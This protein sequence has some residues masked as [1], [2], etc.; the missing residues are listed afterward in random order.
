M[1]RVICLDERLLKRVLRVLRVAH[2]RERQ[3]E[4]GGLVRPYQR[5]VESGVTALDLP[6]QFALQ[7]RLQSRLPLRDRL[8]ARAAR[9]LHCWAMTSSRAATKTSSSSSVLK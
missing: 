9:N 7:V 6:H 3:T 2:H 1:Q 4:S 5:L 8:Y